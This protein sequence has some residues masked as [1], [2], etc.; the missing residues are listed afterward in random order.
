MLRDAT[1]AE[2]PSDLVA[3]L[4]AALRAHRRTPPTNG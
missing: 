4:R 1:A 3:S 2:M